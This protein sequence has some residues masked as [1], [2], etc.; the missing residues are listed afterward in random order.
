[1][2]R[3]FLSIAEYSPDELHHLLELAARLKRERLA[4]GNKPLLQGKVL[5]MIFE[6][7]S[8]RTR[9]SFDI[10]M[11][12]LGGD[13]LYLSPAEVGLG[14]RESIADISRVA[15][16][17]IGTLA[18]EGRQ[19][20][21]RNSVPTKKAIERAKADKRAG[22][23]LP[24]PKKAKPRTRRRAKYA[25][26]VGQGR[27][28]PKRRPRASRA[29]IKALRREPRSTVS[30]KALSRQAARAAAHKAARTRRRRKTGKRR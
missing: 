19:L 4:G 25:H 7:P 5:G 6:K 16:F 11:R 14:Q 26:D 1:M 8:L 20:R 22:V 9:V 30:R 13:A 24:P 29:V 23:D 15:N 27:R 3:H 2:V 21:R 28:K 18:L 10:A 17:G 12:H